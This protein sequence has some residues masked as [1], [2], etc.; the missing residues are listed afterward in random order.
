MRIG[1]QCAMWQWDILALVAHEVHKSTLSVSQRRRTSSEAET[2]RKS[3]AK[4]SLQIITRSTSSS[5]TSSARR[6]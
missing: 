1:K 2:F 4:L 6:S 5:V 3:G